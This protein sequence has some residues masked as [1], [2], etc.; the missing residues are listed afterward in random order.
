MYSLALVVLI[1]IFG[2]NTDDI[3]TIFEPAIDPMDKIRLDVQRIL[4]QDLLEFE[5]EWSAFSPYNSFAKF[6][7][8]KPDNI[9]GLFWDAFY[10]KEGKV[11]EGRA[12]YANAMRHGASIEEA[13]QAYFN[14]AAM[15]RNELIAMNQQFNL[16]HGL[17][18][19]DEQRLFED[20]KYI[21]R[22]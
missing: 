2:F 18:N 8:D 11:N 5:K 1:S 16:K 17:A 9:K 6:V 14:A 4:E 20:G 15:P 22:K 7:S 19:I 10:Y 21:Y 12:A 3:W 13:R